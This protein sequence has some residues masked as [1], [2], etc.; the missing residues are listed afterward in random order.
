ML[1]TRL[2]LFVFNLAF[3]VFQVR[4][5]CLCHNF[6]KKPL[7]GCRKKVVFFVVKMYC[8][9]MLWL[10]GIRVSSRKMDYDYTEYLGPDYKNDLKKSPFTSTIVSNHISWMDS[11]IMARVFRPS[12][13]AKVELKSAPLLGTLGKCLNNIWMPRGRSDEAKK[14]ALDAIIERQN[15]IEQDES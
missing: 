5:L 7:S 10:G 8:Q 6:E 12:Y 2:F 11:I 14:A 15:I 13:T 1:P 3:M 9:F 4:I